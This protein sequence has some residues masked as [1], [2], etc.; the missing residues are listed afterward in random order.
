MG[1]SSPGFVVPLLFFFFFTSQVIELSHSELVEK[2]QL[3]SYDAVIVF[4]A[5]RF[6]GGKVSYYHW[7][8]NSHV[9]TGAQCTAQSAADG[10]AVALHGGGI[11]V[12]AGKK[13]Q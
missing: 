6:M 1:D 5:S 13:Q 12:A 4:R 3:G 11:E 8:N 10:G 2:L 7:R 9:M